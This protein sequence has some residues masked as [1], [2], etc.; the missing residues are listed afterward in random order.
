MHW[1]LQDNLFNEDAYGVLLATLERYGISHSVH[2]VIP[3]IGELVNPPVLDTSNVICMGSYSLR[4]I[5]AKNKWTPGVFDLEPFDFTIQREHW[6]NHMLNFDSTV[7]SFKDIAFEGSAFLRPIHD[8]K[9]FAGGVFDS[10]NFEE[11]KHKVCDLKEDYGS[12]LNADTLVQMTRVKRIFSE[13]RF[14]VI[15]GN[16]VT[17]ST[18]KVGYR[19]NYEPLI[20]ERFT[21]F[22]IERIKE[23][24]PLD[25]FVIDV[26][27]C[28]DGLKVVEINTLNSSGFYA[29]N[30]PKL[31]ESLEL[32][33]NEE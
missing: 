11:W 5:A 6:G 3:F 17:S 10:E 7:R 15:K 19:V 8:S 18:Y 25:A 22:V 13:H 30:I 27:E 21:D 23:W 14:W 4:H 26:C 28:E 33:F 24:Q 20:D 2:K 32:N 12:S 29:A 1:I 16:I 9:V 31:V